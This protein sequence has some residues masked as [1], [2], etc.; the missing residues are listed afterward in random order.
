MTA[1]GG[2]GWHTIAV[3]WDRPSL[4]SQSH[5]FCHYPS[6]IVLMPFHLIELFD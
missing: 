6:L 5:C 3:V 2:R 1:D 4:M